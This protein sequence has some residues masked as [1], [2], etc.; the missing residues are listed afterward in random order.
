MEQK[1]E[2]KSKTIMYG[3]IKHTQNGMPNCKYISSLNKY[4]Q[5]KF[6]H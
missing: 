2:S 4:E 6:A 5:V 1:A 3:N